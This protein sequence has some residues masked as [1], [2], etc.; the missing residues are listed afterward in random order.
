MPFPHTLPPRHRQ[1]QPKSSAPS[2]IAQAVAGLPNPSG[3]SLSRLNS[4]E[5]NMAYSKQDGEFSLPQ[6][7]L[8]LSFDMH[9]IDQSRRSSAMGQQVPFSPKSTD[10][11]KMDLTLDS[12]NSIVER[13]FHFYEIILCTKSSIIMRNH[14]FLCSLIKVEDAS[15]ATSDQPLLGW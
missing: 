12:M 13:Y 14:Q 7:S 8:D 4:G 10:L 1:H 15:A 3:L 5:L 2:V 9:L 11:A 6:P